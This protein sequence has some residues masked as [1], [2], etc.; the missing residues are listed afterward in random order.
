METPRALH[1]TSLRLPLPGAA[2]LLAWAIFSACGDNT[3]APDPP[4][5]T[6]IAVSPA[7]VKIGAIGDT[8][9]VT[10]TITDQ[11]GAAFAGSPVWASDA[12]DVFSV[13]SDGLVEALAEGSGAVTATYESLSAS[14]EVT[15][16]ANRAPVFLLDTAA[17]L[18][19]DVGQSSAGSIGDF[20][21]DPDG[22][23]LAFTASSSDT[24]IVKVEI[25]GEDGVAYGAAAGSAVITL[26][27]IDPGGLSA[28][29]E[30]NV[31]VVASNRAPVPVLDSF[32]TRQATVGDTVT[33]DFSEFFVDPDEDALTFA[34]ASSDSTIISISVDGNL[35]FLRA[36]AAG[37]AG[38]EVTASDPGGLSAAIVLPVEIASPLAPIAAWTPGAKSAH[39]MSEER[40]IERG[41]APP[42]PIE[43]R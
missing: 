17:Q 21:Q 40:R 34:A 43:R 30:M 42:R 4:V 10:A 5:A 6:A 13:S 20:F 23:V 24:S 29:G 14:A 41:P 15:V 31:T 22:D 35:G 26:T 3:A 33:I 32:P 11:N 1:P 39:S 25:Q 28:S 38:I 12:P 27:A 16:D 19:I 7:S 9:R 36:L 18:I 8:V 2:A 37:A